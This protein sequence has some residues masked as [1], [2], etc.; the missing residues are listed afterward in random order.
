MISASKTQITY[1]CDGVTTQF[2]FPYAYYDKAHVIGF[3]IDEAGKETKI[4]TNCDFD[5]VNKKFIYPVSGTAIAAP[6]KI[7][8]KRVTELSQLL[9]LPDEY[10]YRNIEKAQDKLTMIM[11]E[12]NRLIDL[13]PAELE[14]L[15]AG[16][17]NNSIEAAT[18]ANLADLYAQQ[19]YGNVFS[20]IDCGGAEADDYDY[21][22]DGGGADAVV[23]EYATLM[24]SFQ[25]NVPGGF[26]GLDENMAINPDF[27]PSNILTAAQKGVAKGVATLDETGRLTATQAPSSMA[28]LT[29][30]KLTAAQV[31]SYLAQTDESGRV[32]AGSLPAS[33]VYTDGTG[34]IS[35]DVLPVGV[36][37]TY[38]NVLDYGAVGD[39]ATD[40]TAAFTSAIAAAKAS[41]GRGVV[42][43]PKGRFRVTGIEVEN[44][45]ILGV[46]CVD[47]N[48][49]QYTGSSTYYPEG[50]VIETVNTANPLIKIGAGAVLDG[51]TF[52]YPNQLPT[53]STPIVYAPTIKGADYLSAGDG[54]LSIKN[55]LFSNCY[56]GISIGHFRFPYQYPYLAGRSNVV[57]SGKVSVTDCRGYCVNSFMQLVDLYD[58]VT[59]RNVQ[60]SP[61]WCMNI[62][63]SGVNLFKWTIRYGQAFKVRW[64]HMDG[65]TVSES[66]IWGFRIGIAVTWGA[67]DLGCIN[68]VCFDYVLHPLMANKPL[69]YWQANRRFY[70][71]DLVIDAANDSAAHK[72]VCIT[73]GTSAATMA[74]NRTTDSTTTDGTVVWRE[75]GSYDVIGRVTNTSFTGCKFSLWQGSYNGV[76]DTGDIAHV[77]IFGSTTDENTA[78]T[79]SFSGC[80]FQMGVGTMLA[81][82]GVGKSLV[83]NGCSFLGWKYGSSNDNNQCAIAVTS[84]AC[85]AVVSGNQFTAAGAVGSTTGFWTTNN[86]RAALSGN[87]FDS[88]TTPAASSGG[89]T[90]AVGNAAVNCGPIYGATFT[91]NTG[92]SW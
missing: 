34:K 82:T 11:Q 45:T 2:S 52:F 22:F 23:A 69:D 53:L 5:E 75:F 71:G 54:N 36:G 66:L 91:V 43:V 30:G 51:L 83:V 65:L 79:V 68:N 59:V 67:L 72:Y 74:L 20:I 27:L 60:L 46:G 42:V 21:L 88:C 1:Q 58:V 44:A 38:Y 55:C 4:T 16:I 48:G 56:D 33:V 32:P 37:A 80:Q 31:P 40:C 90:I 57:G 86:R 84:G 61:S 39:G 73:G 6:N 18:S 62:W 64:G 25:K 19:A 50:S 13:S 24:Y 89:S 15:I 35:A 17:K 26:V 70:P 49:P 76:T 7:K 29:N 47:E 9:D 10:P 85:N 63:A 28:T 92:N 14:D 12:A 87:V 77:N 3:L 78:S 41:T 81:M 8:L